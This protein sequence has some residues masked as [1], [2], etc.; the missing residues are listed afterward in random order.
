MLRCVHVLVCSHSHEVHFFTSTHPDP[1]KLSDLSVEMYCHDPLIDG[2]R[3]TITW[4]VR[5]YIVVYSVYVP[6]LFT[7]HII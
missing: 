5:Y 3:V 1:P 4:I 2:R 7:T 6:F